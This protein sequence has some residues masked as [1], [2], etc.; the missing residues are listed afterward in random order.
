MTASDPPVPQ[1]AINNSGLVSLDVNVLSATISTAI[2]EAVKTAL[3]KDSLTEIMRQNTVEEGMS[4][5]ATLAGQSQAD[6]S[7]D[8]VA[9]ALSNHVSN[10]TGTRNDS[11][12][13]GPDNV[14]PQQIFTSVSVNLSSQVGSKVK[15]KIWANEYME[16]VALLASTP[17]IDKYA[18][19]MTTSNGPSKQLRLTLEISRT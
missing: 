6:L 16:F 2:S 4:I 14:Q 17:Q 1:P 13:M 11:L 18:L 8:S 19:S 10:L 7:S 15:A 5:I 3:S 9:T 12:L